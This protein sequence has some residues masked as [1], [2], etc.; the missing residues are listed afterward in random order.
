MKRVT[1]KTFFTC[2]TDNATPV[3]SDCR[4]ELREYSIRINRLTPGDDANSRCCGTVGI[5]RSPRTP[6]SHLHFLPRFEVKSYSGVSCSSTSSIPTPAPLSLPRPDR[7][8]GI[9]SPEPSTRHLV[10]RLWVLIS[11]YSW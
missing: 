11:L 3:L 8:S 1:K 6:H 9:S 2:M 7:L 4:A 5:I 10:S